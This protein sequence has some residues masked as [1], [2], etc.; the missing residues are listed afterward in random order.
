[1]S[2]LIYYFQDVIYIKLFLIPYDRAYWL[3]LDHILAPVFVASPRVRFARTCAGANWSKKNCSFADFCC[4]SHI[5]T[6]HAVRLAISH[7]GMF[8]WSESLG[9]E[10]HSFADFCC[11]SY[12]L[13]LHGR[14]L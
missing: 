1:M 5:L 6:L 7:A 9:L 2:N 13:T 8:Y 4:T 10:S 3:Q 14:R 11:T 12:F